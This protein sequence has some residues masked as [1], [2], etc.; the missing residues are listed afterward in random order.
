MLVPSRTRLH[1]ELPSRH[2]RSPELPGG[3]RSGDGDA[4]SARAVF[5]VDESV[6]ER[7]RAGYKLALVPADDERP[8]A[9]P[10]LSRALRRV[11]D[12]AYLVLRPHRWR[13][14]LSFKG[15]RLS[16]GQLLGRMQAERWSVEEA[17]SQFELP[18]AAVDEAVVYGEA[19][20]SLI[21][22]ENAQDARAALDAAA[23]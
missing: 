5:G 21:A 8:D 12:S 9:L 15:R 11:S 14:Q 23:R 2:Q 6:A 16:V 10:E 4:K 1:L 17:A 19:F 13:K 22:A 7:I 20:A 18:I 3:R